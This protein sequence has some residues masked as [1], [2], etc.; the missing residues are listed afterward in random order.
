[1]VKLV[2]VT[3]VRDEADVL[4]YTVGALLAQGVAHVVVVDHGSTDGTR[5]LLAD[6][7]R[8]APVT[9]F[10]EPDPLYLQAMRLTVAATWA[11]ERLRPDF[12]VPFDADECWVLPRRFPRRARAVATAIHDRVPTGLDDPADP[13][14]FTRMAWRRGP[15]YQKVIVRWRPGTRLEMGNHWALSRHG[16]H[17]EVEPCEGLVLHHAPVRSLAQFHRKMLH[18]KR[19]REALGDLVP[20]T[21]SFHWTHFGAI[22]ERGIEATAVEYARSQVVADPRG[23]LVHDP[24]PWTTVGPGGTRGPARA[25]GVVPPAAPRVV[26]VPPRTG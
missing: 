13:N 23:V 21:M 1:M 20:T 2:A 10:D 22:A 14:P 19:A 11:A 15:E 18:G 7:A 25:T 17:V 5:D 4:P 12:V 9:V 16:L 3:M 26:A 8:T 24:I 6:L